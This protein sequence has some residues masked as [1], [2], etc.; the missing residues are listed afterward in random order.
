M[1][2]AHRY[3]AKA[4]FKAMAELKPMLGLELTAT[5][6]TVGAKSVPFRNVI[7]RYDLAQAMADGFVKEPAVATRKD[8]DPKSVDEAELERIK[9]EDGIHAHENV[10]LKLREYAERTGEPLVHPFMLV[11]A[12]DIQHAEALKALVE[13]DGFFGGRYSG[14]MITV[15]SDKSGEESDEAQ[16]RLVAVEHDDQ[17]EIVIHV[18]KL[19]E[20]WD[21]TNLY[22]IVPLRASASDILTEQ[23]LGRGLRLPYGMRTGEEAVDTL[24]VIAHDR[25]DDVIQKAKEPGSLVQKAVE[26]GPDGKVWTA[27][28]YEVTAT[29][30]VEAAMTGRSLPGFAEQP[31]PDSIFAEPASRTVAEVT[32]QVIRRMERELS[33]SERLK[34]ADVRAKIVGRVEELTKPIQG[35]LEGVVARP[36]IKAIVEAVT[37]KLADGMIEIPEIV[38]LP[39]GRVSFSFRDFDLAVPPNTSPQPM[40]NEILVQQLRTDHRTSIAR[41][42]RSN[43]RG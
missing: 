39:E 19:K 33:G 16:A 25:F 31:A 34:T 43:S 1:D 6:K 20:G 22:T 29:T 27:G 13:G 11:V 28:G 41:S 35:T 24:T 7:Y 30:S 18:N 9:L 36:D 17:T 8:F 15:H 14:R 4:A 21:V 5:P 23:T 3:R 32:V 38:V 42:L 2:E 26:I 12:Q 40:S 37:T 10:K